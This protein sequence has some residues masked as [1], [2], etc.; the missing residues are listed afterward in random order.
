MELNARCKS[1]FFDAEYFAGSSKS[2][3]DKNS[4]ILEN[5]IFKHQA[6]VLNKH[7]N[8]TGKTVL[9]L[10]CARCN[11]VYYMRELGI[12]AWG[13]DISEWCKENSHCKE[14]HV[15]H[16][17]GEG[18]PFDNDKFDAVVS[19]E[20]FEHVGNADFL[21][22]EIKRVLTP[23]GTFFATIGLTGHETDKSAVCLNDA[24]WWDNK[25]SKYFISDS[26]TKSLMQEEKLIK[27]YNWTLFCYKK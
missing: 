26:K 1:D 2:G 6:V 4:F 14:F 13:V 17:I 20:T 3:Y 18:I 5:D 11:L 9:D 16:D 27:D 25:I 24:S 7:Y 8:L 22:S 10:G 12:Q 23:D 21:F 15:C 19:F